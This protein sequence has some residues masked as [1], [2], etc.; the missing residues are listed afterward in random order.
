MASS[1]ARNLRPN[2]TT[3]QGAKIIP[4]PSRRMEPMLELQSRPAAIQ[5]PPPACH[6]GEKE[7]AACQGIKLEKARES[8]AKG[9]TRRSEALPDSHYMLAWIVWF[10]YVKIMLGTGIKACEAPKPEYHEQLK[11]GR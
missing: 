9:Q 5:R 7:A 6:S 3:V 2:P 4:F 1:A 11:K 8:K 10:A